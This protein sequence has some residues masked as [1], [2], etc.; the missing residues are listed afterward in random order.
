MSHQPADDQCLKCGGVLGNWNQYPQTL[1]D[2][3]TIYALGQ[4]C[5]SCG[6]IFW[7]VEPQ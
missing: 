5:L 1:G 4:E 7:E 6:T 3:V 2:G